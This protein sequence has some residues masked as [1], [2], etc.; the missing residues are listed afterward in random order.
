MTGNLTAFHKT[1][2]GHLH[3]LKDIPCEDYSSSFSDE[4]RRYY[5]AAVAD[6]HGDPACTRSAYGS[7]A[8]VEIAKDCLKSFAESYLRRDTEALLNDFSSSR[9]THQIMKQ[10]TDTIISRWYQQIY[11]HL[12]QEPLSQEE[13]NRAGS[14]AADYST[15]KRLAHIY[16]TT[17][18]AALW[19]PTHLILIQQGDGHCEIFYK[20][21]NVDQPVPQDDRCFENVTTSMCDADVSTRIR[22]YIISLEQQP[23]IACFIGSDGVEDSF[24]DA[25]GTHA[26]YQSL[27]NELV[28]RQPEEFEHYLD[29]MLPKFS[30][31]GCG[32][33]VSIAG[34]VDIEAIAPFVELFQTHSRRYELS[35]KKRYYDGKIHS[36][37]RKHDILKKRVED[38]QDAWEQKDKRLQILQKLDL[39]LCLVASNLPVQQQAVKDAW[40]H[41]QAVKNEYS[42]YD[43]KY[44]DLLKAQQDVELQI[45]SLLNAAPEKPL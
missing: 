10:L 45:D 12:A 3:I 24:I 42:E 8:A 26:F 28:Y 37:T 23:V 29:D 44:Q 5:I 1:V 15:G 40:E 34:I 19:L 36:M 20:D 9:S 21:G 31:T 16:G 6:G 27:S 38:A 33:D 41:Y 35:E 18:I 30:K 32:D 11:R 14:Y 4:N 43:L 39:C 13:L 22:H 7:N 25:E 2:R 17:L